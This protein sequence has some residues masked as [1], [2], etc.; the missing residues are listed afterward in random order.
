M[1]STNETI[2]VLFK[3]IHAI[4]PKPREVINNTLIILFINEFN[5]AC[6]KLQCKNLNLTLS[7]FGNK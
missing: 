4:E 6:R 5:D 1:T 2:L 7:W 3:F